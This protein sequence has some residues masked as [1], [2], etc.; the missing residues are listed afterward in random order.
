MFPTMFTGLVTDIGTIASIKREAKGLILRI[1]CPGDFL[2]DTRVG[3]SIAVSGVCLTVTQ[4]ENQIFHSDISSESAKRTTIPSWRSGRKV[5]LEK[6]LRPDGKLGG[7][8]V[9]GHVDGVAKIS[10]VI[11]QGEAELIT[12]ESSPE[13]VRMVVPK[14]SVA[15]D[16]ISLTPTDRKD[17]TFTIAVIPHTLEKTTLANAR[18]GEEINVEI[19]IF[20]LYIFEF[21]KSAGLVSDNREAQS[22]PLDIETLRSEGY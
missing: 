1:E 22:S 5:N 13:I 15:I 17:S 6:S 9:M 8:F 4:I 12:F 3:E 21:L 19:D 18:V 2:S 16:G 11:K 14:G 10:G 7:H 20:A